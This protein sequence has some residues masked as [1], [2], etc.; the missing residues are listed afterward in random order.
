M[1]Y[2]FFSTGL[3]SAVSVTKATFAHGSQR[4]RYSFYV[5]LRGQNN[6]YADD[7]YT[8]IHQYG[9]HYFDHVIGPD[10]RVNVNLPFSCFLVL[11]LE[12]RAMSS[13]TC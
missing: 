6:G 9:T 13:L 5:A 4:L 1:L 11:L 7:E 8:A 3:I 10:L 12:D 2:R